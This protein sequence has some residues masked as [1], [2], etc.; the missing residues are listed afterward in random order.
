MDT[1][2]ECSLRGTNGW[3]LTS[4]V[5]CIQMPERPR[6][7]AQQTRWTNKTGLDI[8]FSAGQ[9]RAEKRREGATSRT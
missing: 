8:K 3:S 4:V 1:G 7:Y 6:Y 2:R 5:P 9:F